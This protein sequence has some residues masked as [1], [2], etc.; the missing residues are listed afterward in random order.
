MQICVASGKGRNQRPLVSLHNNLHSRMVTQ[1]HDSQKHH[2]NQRGHSTCVRIHVQQGQN[3]LSSLAQRVFIAFGFNCKSVVLLRFQ[4]APQRNH[5]S[6]HFETSSINAAQPSIVTF[7]AHQHPS[8][9]DQTVSS[10]VQ[11][12]KSRHGKAG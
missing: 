7:T 5:L 3:H 1:S 11:K 8:C 6:M 2:T 10:L 12:R 4:S 9:L